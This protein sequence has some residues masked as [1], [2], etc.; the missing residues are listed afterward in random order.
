MNNYD[1]WLQAGLDH[2]DISNPDLEDLQKKV[3]I[4]Q[5]FYK[6]VV[7]ALTSHD[8]L[9]KDRLLRDLEEMTIVFEDF[10]FTHTEL[11]VDRLL[12]KEEIL[13]DKISRG[14]YNRIFEVFHE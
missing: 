3:E 13:W 9:D 5:E 8:P 7:Y 10:N 4:A 11:T 1:A 12:P 2:N 14:D 6:K